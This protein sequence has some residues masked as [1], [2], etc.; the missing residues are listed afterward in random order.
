[1][2]AGL[3]ALLLLL[4]AAASAVAEPHSVGAGQLATVVGPDHGSGNK[5]PALPTRD[6]G[7]SAKRTANFRW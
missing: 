7:I 5:L 4:V 3:V 6:S 1:V 2:P